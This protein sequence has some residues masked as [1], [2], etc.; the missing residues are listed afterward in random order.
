MPDPVQKA[1]WVLQN[2]NIGDIPA[3]E[4]KSIADSEN[5]KYL[6]NPYRGKWDGA[7]AFDGDK[8]AI[9]VNTSIN[10]PARHNFTFAH[11]LGHYFLSHR[12]N[13][14][15]DGQLSIRCTISETDTEQKGR[16]RE[17]NRFAVEL[18]MPQDRFGLL[19]AG[20][21]IDFALI[22]GLAIEFMVSKQA[23]S[24]RIAE[25]TSKPCVIIFSQ[26]RFITSSTSSRAA[27]GF[28]GGHAILPNETRAS[29]CVEYKRQQNNFSECDSNMWLNRAVPNQTIYECTRAVTMTVWL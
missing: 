27:K 6:L 15:Q 1:K 2:K 26:N 23:C 19:M 29:E 13:Y 18:L 8:R 12:P 28:F 7:L 22:S 16:E 9:L 4:L 5:I 20:A 11:E 3:L 21:E 14:K 24:Y 17:A 10:N 25:L